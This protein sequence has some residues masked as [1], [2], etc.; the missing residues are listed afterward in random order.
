MGLTEDYSGIIWV[1]TF[2][3]G[4]NKI[5]P[6]SGE[7][8]YYTENDGLPNNVVYGVIEDK[9]YNLWMSTNEGISKFNPN[10]ETFVNF[11]I[12]DGLQESEFNAGAY[13]QSTNG[14][15]YFG[16]VNGLNVFYPDRINQNQFVPPIEIYDFKLFNKSVA[17]SESAS[18]KTI[19]FSSILE[20]DTIILTYKENVFSFSFTALNFSN[21][22]KNEYAYILKNFETDWNRVG[23][24]RYATY[25][26]LPAGEYTFQVIGSSS[27]GVWNN[28]GKSIKIIII[29]PW[30]KTKL[31]YAFLII[32]FIITIIIYNRFRVIRFKKENLKLDKRVK[33]RTIEIQ[34]KNKLLEENQILLEQ[35]KEEIQKH[36]IAL[37]DANATKDKFF[38]N[39]G[40]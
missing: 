31:F 11:G 24:R 37:R 36:M 12:E 40:T 30:W 10:N 25:T 38:L 34:K 14:E 32:V 8:A 22:A 1:S 21:P 15:I 16:G 28:E 29:P 7:I 3:G 9:D 39:Y 6:I 35:Q 19:L 13:Y 23:P 17:V 26:N 2:G 27:N 20:T 4:L 18:G 5:D 33:E